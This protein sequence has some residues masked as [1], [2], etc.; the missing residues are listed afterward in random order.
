MIGTPVQRVRHNYICIYTTLKIL[1]YIIMTTD[2]LQ[3]IRYFIN[4]IF[5]FREL[6]DLSPYKHAPGH[7]T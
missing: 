3:P 5:L 6:R 4:L 2:R 7:F 1:A